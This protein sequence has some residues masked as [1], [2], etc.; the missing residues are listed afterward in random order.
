MLQAGEYRA[1]AQ[2][3]DVE[4]PESLMIVSAFTKTSKSEDANPEEP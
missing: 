4:R 1:I 2:T 3:R